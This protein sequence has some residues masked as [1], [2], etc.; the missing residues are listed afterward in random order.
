MAAGSVTEP[1][2]EVASGQV[3][4]GRPARAARVLSDRNR[5]EFARAVRVYVEYAGNYLADAAQLPG[6]Q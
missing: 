3:W 2:T 5:E 4:S 1:G 6:S